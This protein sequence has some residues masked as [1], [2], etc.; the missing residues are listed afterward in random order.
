MEGMEAAV[1]EILEVEMGVETEMG[2]VVITTIITTG[3]ATIITTTMEE[4][5]VMA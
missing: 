1:E 5:T 4:L 2:M 3:I